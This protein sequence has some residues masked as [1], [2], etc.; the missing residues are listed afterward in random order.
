[1]INKRIEQATKVLLERN[2]IKTSSSRLIE[3]QLKKRGLYTYLDYGKKIDGVD[4]VIVS[5]RI[6][7]NN[8]AIDSEVIPYE[9]E[10]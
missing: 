10:E 1:M 4:V 5:L 8:M 2:N 3:H 7:F 6:S 9:V